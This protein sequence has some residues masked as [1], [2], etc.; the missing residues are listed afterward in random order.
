MIEAVARITRAVSVPVTA[1]IEHGYAATPDAVSEIVL[2]VIAAGAVGINLED[3]L[4]GASDLEPLQLQCD[5]IAGVV[6]AATTAGV[7]VVVNA[8]TDVF[9]RRIGSASEQLAVAAA[10]GRAFLDAGADC[11]F[12]PGVTD[13]ETIAA[14]V[15]AIGGPLNVLAV[16]GSPPVSELE[17][18]GV[19]RVSVGSGP[20]RA[21][22]AVVQEIA[23]EL[24]AS[25]T[26]TSYTGRQMPYDA[27]NDSHARMT[28]A[29]ASFLAG[30]PRLSLGT[31]PTPLVRLE[32]LGERLGID[33]WMK[34]DEC[35]GVAL[36][37]NK[38]RKLEFVLADARS[39]GFSTIVTTGPLTS[40]HT[41]MTAAAARRA[42]F[43][44][45]C[46]VGGTAPARP[47]GNL[48]LLDYFGATLHFSPMNTADPAPDED[49]ALRRLSERVTRDTGGYWIPPG[50][51]MPEAEP[52]YMNAVLEIAGQR[53]G[54]DFDDVVLAY[55]TGSTTSGVLLGLAMAGCSTRVWPI[56]IESRR[57]VQDVFQ[58]PPPAQLV[59]ES[60]AHF[61]LP[62]DADAVPPHEVV[63]GLADEGYGVPSAG[64]DRALRLMAS[65]EGYLLDPVYTAKAF[66]G[67]LALLAEGRIP[68]GSR[69]LFL[70]TGG[71][72][73]T[74]A[75]E[76]QYRR[77]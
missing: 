7:R 2:R 17:V 51:T 29:L 27:M 21:T 31:F 11:V 13:K 53:A 62:I 75:A 45:H 35:S 74:P 47:S 41:M 36:G 25:G 63:F 33:L 5:K 57:A 77:D 18:L 70:H 55:G 60:V 1:D 3:C 4:P 44:V 22:L 20:M 19:A 52:G 32:R 15:A 38:T 9:L 14:L 61:G 40:N 65:I 71:L 54:F 66:H 24:R 42:G 48:L 34:R 23:R 30:L 56:A 16:A 10:R 43:A 50:G 8:R 69:V 12:V 68:R 59:A 6:R 49:E 46:T 37:G 72:S 76:K 64:A 26:Y 67:L 58:M 39:R 73:M 28:A